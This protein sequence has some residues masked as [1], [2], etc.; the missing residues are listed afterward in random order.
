MVTTWLRRNAV[1]VVLAAIAV[2]IA[3]WTFTHKPSQ[4]ASRR[5][6]AVARAR[7]SACLL[8][9]PVSHI[10]VDGARL[11]AIQLAGVADWPKRCAPYAE[12]VERALP[13]RDGKIDNAGSRALNGGHVFQNETVDLDLKSLLTPEDDEPILALSDV[14]R[15]VPRPAAPVVLPHEIPAIAPDGSSLTDVGDLDLGLVVDGNV[16]CRFAA[17]DGGLEPIAHCGYPADSLMSKRAL[18]V[19]ATAAADLQLVTDD[20]VR[21]FATGDKIVASP[22]VAQAWNVAGTLYAWPADAT[23]AVR[24]CTCC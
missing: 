16:A 11:R 2:G 17:H 9:T 14:A 7:L 8:G 13:H 12:A 24:R 15:E 20:G 1:V 22:A 18:P 10:A 3:T 19:H 4:A 21:A 5:D 6:V 23:R